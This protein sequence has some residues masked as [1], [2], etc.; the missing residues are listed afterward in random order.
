MHAGRC[1]TWDEVLGVCDRGGG[2]SQE[3]HSVAIGSQQDSVQ[4]L[5]WMD[6]IF[7]ASPCVRMLGIWACSE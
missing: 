5:P 6:T 4:G 2:R 1:W 3:P 7:E